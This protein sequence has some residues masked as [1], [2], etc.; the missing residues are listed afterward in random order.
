MTARQRGVSLM[1]LIFGL[2]I[3]VVL[4]LFAM[5]VIPSYLEYSSAKGAIQAIAQEKP[6][7]TAAEVRNAFEA[8]AQVD[9]IR[10]LKPQ[11]LEITREGN[12]TVIEFAYRQEVPLFTNVGLYIDYTATTREQ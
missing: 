5:K 2:F 4:A 11:D 8:R 1:G 10:V 12:Q 7:A 9:N 6:G 3:L